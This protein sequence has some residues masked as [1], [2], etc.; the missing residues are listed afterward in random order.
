M[1]LSSN[2]KV[3]VYFALFM[4]LNNSCFIDGHDGSVLSY[5]D[6]L[7]TESGL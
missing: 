2:E 6:D 5:F 7:D 3:C 1:L 4:G